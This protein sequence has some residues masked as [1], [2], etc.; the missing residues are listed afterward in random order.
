MR[1]KDNYTAMRRRALGL[2]LLVFLCANVTW[3]QT[4]NFLECAR[5]DTIEVHPLENAEDVQSFINLISEGLDFGIYP[6]VNPLEKAMALASSL[7]LRKERASIAL[8]LLNQYHYT[9]A[10][11]TKQV[12]IAMILANEVD[13]LPIEKVSTALNLIGNVSSSA[14][15]HI[16]ALSYYHQAFEKADST[17]P[18][19]RLYPLGNLAA[20]YLSNED[21]TTAIEILHKSTRLVKRIQDPEEIAYNS[22]YDFAELGG[23]HL[24]Q[25]NVDSAQHYLEKAMVSR[26]FFDVD[27][28]RYREIQITLLPNLIRLY[29]K[30]GKSEF[31]LSYIDT[32][33]SSWPELSLLLKAEHYASIGQLSKALA[34]TDTPI[35][36][37][38]AL[39]KKRIELRGT[40]SSALGHYKIAQE[41]N[42]QLLLIAEESLTRSK[43]ELVTISKAQ[44]EASEKEREADIVRYESKLELLETRQRNWIAG[45]LILFSLGIA[46][47]FNQRYRKSHKRSLNLSKIVS[48]H[49]K[50]LILANEQL[51]SK[52]K[53]MERFNHLLSH[54]LR[55]PLRSISGFTSILSRKAKVHT[56]LSEDFEMLSKSVEQLA[57]LMT[58]VE[59]LR[60]V[61]ERKLQ[62]TQVNLKDLI[63]KISKEVKAKYDSHEI[64]IDV[65]GDLSPGVLDE[66]FLTNSLLELVDNGAK[67]CENKIAHITIEVVQ[68]EDELK[69]YVQDEGIGINTKFR[70]QI[71][72]IFKRL[73][74]REDFVGSGVG[75][76]LV[77][78]ATEKCRGSVELLESQLGKGSTF[79]L[80]LP[81]L[82]KAPAKK[83]R[84]EV[85]LQA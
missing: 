12:S 74:R 58:G 47:W 20:T 37:D 78:L 44:M 42:N 9:D 23:I 53:S 30:K 67:F 84:R 22:V 18:L 57:Y 49:E 7:D 45:A 17:R 34:L 62:P 56:E 27:H 79:M 69:I 8:S 13:N 68:N 60:R 71:F 64:I 40:L 51:A 46:L 28:K 38:L 16:S 77:K 66:K 1:K 2:V 15:D 5:K 50:D 85:A 36:L 70:E 52:V 24:S 31:S 33:H 4:S 76:S 19:D 73:N 6:S 3:A 10:E 61:E 32:L 80:S 83:N 14:G 41:A 72:G 39:D 43:K 11:L 35:K 21:T 65:K 63:T 48:Q 54:D 55:E 25:G 59:E 81:I 75:L 82:K 26:T 29:I